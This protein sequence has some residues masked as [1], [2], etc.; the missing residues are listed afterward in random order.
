[1]NTIR[2][3]KADSGQT[4]TV[5]QLVKKLLSELEDQPNEFVGL[6]EEKIIREMATVGERY[7]AFLAK[8]AEE[9]WIGVV[10]V[11]EAFAIY[12][13]GSYGIIDEM[14]VEPAYRSQGVGRRLIDAVKKLGQQRGWLRLDV[15]APPEKKWQ[16][17]VRF[18]E[19]HGF[20]F[21]GPKLRFMFV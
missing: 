3:I 5:L 9:E 19:S 14:Y 15:T 13:N 8:N 17:S 10:T 12:A 20:V 1:M 11:M 16:R 21:T 4:K 18:Y 2:I 7:T 6:D